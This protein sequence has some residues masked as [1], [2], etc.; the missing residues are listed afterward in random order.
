M[1]NMSFTTISDS[2]VKPN[3]KTNASTRFSE[4][5]TQI[6]KMLYIIAM[7]VIISYRLLVYE[8]KL[9]GVNSTMHENTTTREPRMRIIRVEN[10]GKRNCINKAKDGTARN[11]ERYSSLSTISQLIVGIR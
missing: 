8:K 6:I 4:K 10:F 11:Q 1:Y 5:E 9:T 3:K 7:I 2:I